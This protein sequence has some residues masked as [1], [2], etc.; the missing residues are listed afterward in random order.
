MSRYNDRARF[1]CDPEHVHPIKNLSQL[2][3]CKIN[4]RINR[5]VALSFA[6]FVFP[7]ITDPQMDLGVSNLKVIAHTRLVPFS[8]ELGT[9]HP[10]TLIAFMVG[11]LGVDNGTHTF[12]LGRK[13]PWESEDIQ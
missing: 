4:D 10:Q 12:L 11:K 2:F 6:D 3:G 1:D 7:R 5:P 8:R 9:F 13:D